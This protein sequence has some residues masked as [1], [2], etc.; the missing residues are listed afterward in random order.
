MRTFLILLFSFAGGLALSG[1]VANLYRILA[2]KPQSRAA[3]MIH[4]AVMMLAGPSVLFENATRSFR[5]RACSGVAYGFAVAIAT[6]WA[7]VIG[8]VMVELAL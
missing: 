4:Y 8:V 6:Y 5:A 7:F 1:I 2:R 3:T